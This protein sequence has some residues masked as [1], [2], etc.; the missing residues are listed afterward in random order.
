M[1]AANFSENLPQKTKLVYIPFYEIFK[2]DVS[3]MDYYYYGY[4]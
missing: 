4:R 3:N 2:K 1:N